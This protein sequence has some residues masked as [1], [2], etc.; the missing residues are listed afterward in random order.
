MKRTHAV[1]VKHTV[2]YRMI[3]D[4]DIRSTVADERRIVK[5]LAVHKTM[6]DDQGVE[7]VGDTWDAEIMV[8]L[9]MEDVAP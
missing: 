2:V 1:T 5:E 3:V 4:T 9:N 7:L 6:R 8:S